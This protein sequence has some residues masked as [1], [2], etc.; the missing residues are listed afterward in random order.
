MRT[1]HIWL[2]ILQGRLCWIFWKLQFGISGVNWAILVYIDYWI[3]NCKF[4]N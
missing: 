3:P 2:V 4:A 1:G